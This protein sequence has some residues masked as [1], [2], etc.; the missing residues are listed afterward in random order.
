VG[1]NYTP[2]KEQ[3]EK[4]SYNTRQLSIQYSQYNPSTPVFYTAFE[5]RGAD[6]VFFMRGKNSCEKK[7]DFKKKF[8]Y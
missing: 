8:C 4:K 1:A 7:G 3:N 5:L 6:T 2:T